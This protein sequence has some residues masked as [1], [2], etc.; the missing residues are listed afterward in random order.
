MGTER[1]K[2]QKVCSPIMIFSITFLTLN[3]HD[4]DNNVFR[5]LLTAVCTGKKMQRLRS[6]SRSGQEDC[7]DS[8]FQREEEG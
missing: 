7:E 5:F 3:I 8:F 4:T 6:W 2:V 1:S